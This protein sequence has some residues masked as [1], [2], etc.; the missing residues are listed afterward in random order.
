VAGLRSVGNVN[1]RSE[2][3]GHHGPHVGEEPFRLE[4]EGGRREGGREGGMRRGTGQP[5][6][7][8]IANV[9]PSLPPSLPRLW[10]A[11]PALPLS[12][13]TA[14]KPRMLMTLWGWNPM[15]IN[16][17]PKRMEVAKNSVQV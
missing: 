8:S 2:S 15:V 10:I 6:G 7:R 3:P 16:A 11:K 14:L 13:L 17:R 9:D 1:A 5:R 12:P 4:G